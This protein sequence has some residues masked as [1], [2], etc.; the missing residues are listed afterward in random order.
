YYMINTTPPSTYETL[1]S[2]SSLYIPVEGTS[3]STRMLRGSIKGV[4]TVYVVAVDNQYG[5]SQS[6]AITGAYT[7]NSTLPD[8][9][10]NLSLADTSIKSVQ[11]W[12]ASLNWEE[13]AY[14]G[15][16]DLT[17]TIQRSTDGTTWATV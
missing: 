7:L 5:Y 1:S 4:N 14:K 8:P 11:L 2:N 3:V 13:P 12:R 16:S 9:I 6:N 17:Y 15:D 10:L